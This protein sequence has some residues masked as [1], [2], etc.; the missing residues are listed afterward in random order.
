M[1]SNLIT[2][3]INNFSKD[4]GVH[5]TRRS[6]RS[7]LDSDGYISLSVVLNTFDAP[8][9]E[10]HAWA[11]CYLSL[12]YL[13]AHSA[14]IDYPEK[15]SRGASY[16]TQNVECT[17]SIK[18]FIKNGDLVLDVDYI[19]HRKEIVLRDR[20]QLLPQ[21]VSYI[22]LTIYTAL[23]FGLK[24]EEERTLSNDLENVLELMVSSRD[25]VLQT[26]KNA[27]LAHLYKS[28]MEDE[29]I[30]TYCNRVCNNLVIDTLDYAKFL[31]IA[32]RASQ[33]L[34]HFQGTGDFSRAEL[35]DKVVEDS[36]KNLTK[37]WIHVVRELRHGV[38][39]KSW[40][41]SA[42]CKNRRKEYKKTPYEL[43]MDDIRSQ[44][45]KLRKTQHKDVK[46]NRDKHDT[47]M[48]II[49]SRPKLKRSSDR[50]IKPVSPRLG[51]YDELMRSIRQVHYL[52]PVRK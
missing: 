6:S 23:D 10:N 45:Y 20:E 52:R 11:L 22:A 21:L 5:V 47:M 1:E 28:G 43:L 30:E 29:D 7:L 8:I 31:H 37:S 24:E 34:R 51:P 33:M 32:E 39:L 16:W 41:D 48:E 17:D 18:L 9:N 25:D 50:I 42:V 19:L 4:E 26:T 14:S 15:S 27:C 38:K 12:K 46:K 44:R 49:R 3:Q 2:F 40:D 35:S 36:F 13:E